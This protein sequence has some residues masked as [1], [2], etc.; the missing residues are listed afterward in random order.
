MRSSSKEVTQKSPRQAA[1]IIFTVFLPLILFSWPQTTGASPESPFHHLKNRPVIFDEPENLSHELRKCGYPISDGSIAKMDG[2]IPL[3]MADFFT[4]LPT[5]PFFSRLRQENLKLKKGRSTA[6]CVKTKTYLDQIT[7]RLVKRS[8]LTEYFFETKPKLGIVL[9]CSGKATLPIARTSPRKKLLIPSGLPLN[10]ES[11]DA[12][13]AVLAHELSH[14]S[15]RHPQRLYHALS[16]TPQTD[17]HNVIRKTKLTHERE[18][19][20]TGLKI[21]VNAGYDAVASIE[22]LRTVADLLK[23]K[24]QLQ[25]SIKPRIHHDP[26]ETRIQI[27][28]NQIAACNYPTSQSRV[29][30]D[31]Q[32][33]SELQSLL[34]TETPHG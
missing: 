18:A 28:K 5:R 1:W 19:D 16:S 34:I 7:E 14:M 32:V 3:L 17:H 31:S 30:I 25:L 6:S 29:P 4:S 20:I 8:S 27:L 24:K 33:K 13:A 26:L 15:L 22:H 11:E 12:I 23:E 2:Q 9:L 10:A 21:L